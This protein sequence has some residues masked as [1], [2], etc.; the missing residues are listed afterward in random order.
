[1]SKDQKSCKLN[2]LSLSVNCL[3]GNP[4]LNAAAAAAAADW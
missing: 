1:M 3:A 2:V 4:E